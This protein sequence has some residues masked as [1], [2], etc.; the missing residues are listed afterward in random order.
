MKNILTKLILFLAFAATG[1][2]QNVIPQPE[3]MVMNGGSFV[4]DDATA[5]YTN[6]KGKDRRFILN[7]MNDVMAMKKTVSNDKKDGKLIRLILSTDTGGNVDSVS[8]LHLQAYTLQIS[9]DGVTISSPSSTGI[10]YGLQTLRQLKKENTIPCCHVTDS[11]LFAYR[12]LMIDCSR[13]FW[14]KSFI[15][16]Q[17]DAMAYFKMNRLHLH[18]TDAG[19]WRMEIHKYPRLTSETAYRTCSDWSKWWEH[20]DRKYCH[21]DDAGAYGGFYTQRD[22]K[23]IVRYAAQRGIVVVPEIEMPGHSEEATYAY[24]YLSC[25]GKPGDLCPGNEATY[26]FLENVLKEVMH[27]FPSRYIHIGGDEAG[28]TQWDSCKLCRIRMA[29]N[30]LSSTAMLQSYLTAR[31]EK[32]L[33]KHG[34]RLLGWDEILEGQLAPNATVMS[35]RG[36]D[37]G[38]KAATMGHHAIMSPGKYCYINMC[39]DAPTSE[40]KSMGGY[41]PL[42]RTYSYN[43]IPHQ[44]A[45]SP[46]RNYID[47]VQANLW[48]EYIETEECAEHMIY[49]RLLAVAEIGWSKMKTPYSDFR[50]RALEGVK[51]LFANGYHPFDLSKEVGQREESKHLVAHDG[52]GKRVTYASDYAEQYSAAGDSALTDGRLGN[53]NY[54]DGAWQ[55]FIEK[56]RL[57][58]VIDMDSVTELHDIAAEYMQNVGPEIY[59]P[60]EIVIS[61]SDDGKTYREIYH[62]NSDV[63]INDYYCLHNYEWQGHEKA[64][65]I[66]YQAHAGKYQGWIFTDEIIVNRK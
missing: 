26:T 63:N 51:W 35:W 20:G 64:R 18:L 66:H 21:K 59:L 10:F 23:Q 47:G 19:G 61:V 58:V 16:K 4:I 45:D 36:E 38:I 44:L 2:A 65:Y 12:G 62:N 32:F 53:W 28:R 50:K 9:N 41:L 49:P 31:I 43:P 15:M 40:P 42:Q 34:R 24:P 57:D 22:L 56:G 5:V 33:N 14:N 39:Q 11:P 7:Y 37:G 46:L 60:A 29:E 13:H 52:R 30:N 55:G 25:N 8:D 54:D 27:V 48:T 6:I 3:S 1:N 17:I